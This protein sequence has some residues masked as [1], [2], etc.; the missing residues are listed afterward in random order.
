[1]GMLSSDVVLSTSHPLVSSYQVLWPL[2]SAEAWPLSPLLRLWNVSFSS[3][4]PSAFANQQRSRCS[5]AGGKCCFACILSPSTRLL[6]VNQCSRYSQKT[7]KKEVLITSVLGETLPLFLSCQV[8]FKDGPPLPL[9]GENRSFYRINLEKLCW[10][11]I[12]PFFFS[13]WTTVS[14]SPTTS[15]SFFSWRTP[16]CTAFSLQ[17]QSFDISWSSGQ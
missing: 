2:P 13:G 16:C 1:M 3:L 15:F 9:V 14:V 17:Q 4:L 11:W 7:W 5:W 12:F 8:C 6:F 10:T